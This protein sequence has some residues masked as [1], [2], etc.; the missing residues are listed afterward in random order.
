MRLQTDTNKASFLFIMMSL[1]LMATQAAECQS[2]EPAKKSRGQL[3]LTSTNTFTIR[4]RCRA[5]K[6]E[7]VVTPLSTLNVERPAGRTT[8]YPRRKGTSR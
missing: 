2:V 8:G 1:F 4:S 5:K 6:G 3:C 7:Q